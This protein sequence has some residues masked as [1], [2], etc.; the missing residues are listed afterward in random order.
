MKGKTTTIESE[1]QSTNLPFTQRVLSY[2]LPSKFKV[3]SIPL[4]DG[5]TDHMEHLEMFR[6]HVA[7]REV[8]NEIACRAF[9]L[10]L[11]G[12]GREWF[13]SIPLNTI[14]N[15]TNLAKHFLTHFMSMHRRK[16]HVSY[17]MTIQQ[18]D[19][20]SLKDYIKC[21]RK[22]RLT[23]FTTPGNVILP[24]LLNGIHPHNPLALEMAHNP[25][26]YLQEFMDKVAKFI[27]GKE[28]VQTLTA[29]TGALKKE[30]PKVNLLP[31]KG[32]FNRK[33]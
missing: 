16:M 6:A 7:L 4:Y 11:T 25:P 20:E 26:A 28:S 29:A 22:E 2:P 27:N 3:P 31:K 17:L 21:F 1:V 8:P 5:T 23:V 13:T 18:K 10:T 32:L 30:A 33:G 12:S 15:F 9:P 19:L 14:D 24:A